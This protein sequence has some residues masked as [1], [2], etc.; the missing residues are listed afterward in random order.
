MWQRVKDLRD[1]AL[2]RCSPGANSGE[3]AQSQVA[4]WEVVSEFQNSRSS[5][6]VERF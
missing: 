5:F 3:V 4:L 1:G 6:E 2:S